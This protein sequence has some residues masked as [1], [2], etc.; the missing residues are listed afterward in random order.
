LHFSTREPLHVFQFLIHTDLSRANIS[1]RQQRERE[2]SRE[3]EKC[4]EQRTDS[5]EQREVIEHV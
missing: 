4:R 1:K 3:R 2:S 5:R